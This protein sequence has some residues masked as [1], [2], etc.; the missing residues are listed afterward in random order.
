VLTGG[1]KD[2][3]TNDVVFEY[4]R[5]HSSPDVEGMK[6]CWLTIMYRFMVLDL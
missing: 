4:E 3:D 6:S 1:I 5:M 2:P